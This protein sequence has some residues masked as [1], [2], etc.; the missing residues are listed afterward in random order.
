MPFQGLVSTLLTTV[1]Y[2]SV[3]PYVLFSLY[4]WAME[5]QAFDYDQDNQ[6]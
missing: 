4:L 2:V 1:N 6:F 5:C 3:C